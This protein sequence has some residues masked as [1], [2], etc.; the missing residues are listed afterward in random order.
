MQSAFARMTSLRLR[1]TLAASALL[2]LA[3]AIFLV[4]WYGFGAVATAALALGWRGLLAL[5]VLHLCL[6][7]ACGIAWRAVMEPARRVGIVVA[8]AARVLRDA[9][10][11]LLPISPA[12]GAVMGARA[13]ILARMPGVASFASVVVDMTLEL[14]AQIGFTA[15]GIAVLLHGGWA[16]QLGTPALAGLA[17]AAVVAF[18]FVMAQRAGLFRMLERF[19]RRVM[20]RNQAPAMPHDEGVHE[21]I[22]DAYRRHSGIVVGLAGHFIAWTATSLEAWLALRLIGAPLPLAAVLAL[23][24]LTYAVRSTA[25]FVPSGLGVQEGG[26]VFLGAIF[27]LGPE[28]ALALSLAKRAREMAIGIPALLVWQAIEARLWRGAPMRKAP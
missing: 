13:L 14:F 28:T 12:G 6:M 5:V 17:V 4:G 10:G 21:V 15:L 11:E 22:R 8:T 16:P 24:S 2:G 19:T 20:L 27:G 23:E 26:Y 9:G 7:L 1:L 3:L 18:G 25:F